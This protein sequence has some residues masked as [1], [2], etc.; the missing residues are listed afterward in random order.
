LKWLF[1]DLAIMRKKIP[2]LIFKT[3]SLLAFISIV[4]CMTFLGKDESR[5]NINFKKL[6]ILPLDCVRNDPESWRHGYE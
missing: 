4:V 1:R 3:I 6:A 5:T 2:S